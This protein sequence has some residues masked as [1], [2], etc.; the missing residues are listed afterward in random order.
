MCV[1]RCQA[2]AAI[3]QPAAGE[4]LAAPVAGGFRGGGS[5]GVGKVVRCALDTAGVFPTPS[6]NWCDSVIDPEPWV[7]RFSGVP[8]ASRRSP[9][10]LSPIISPSGHAAAAKALLGFRACAPLVS[11]GLKRSQK[12]WEGPLGS[13]SL[14]VW[15]VLT[16]L[17][18]LEFQDQLP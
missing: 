15:L 14:F 6:P 5:L 3:A 4:F 18:T 7:S 10:P 16:W 13:C 12:H 11:Q 9:S 1:G 2:R 8:P 17:L